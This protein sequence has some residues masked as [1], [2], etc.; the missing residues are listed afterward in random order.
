M[1]K[2]PNIVVLKAQIRTLERPYVGF[3]KRPKMPAEVAEA[4][5]RLCEQIDTLLG[6]K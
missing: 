6:I 5:W 2:Q 4:I 3:G 1:A